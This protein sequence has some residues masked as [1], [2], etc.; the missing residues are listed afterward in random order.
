M[1]S[2]LLLENA[3]HC[4]I[5]YVM[6]LLNYSISISDPPVPQISHICYDDAT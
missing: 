5:I 4:K 6:L 3:F 1:Q 2:L